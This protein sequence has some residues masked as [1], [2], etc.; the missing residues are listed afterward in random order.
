M[1]DWLLK[2]ENEVLGYLKY[3]R[4]DQPFFYFRFEP[5]PAFATVRRLFEDE[6]RLLDGGRD[7]EWMEICEQIDGLDLTLVSATD[8]TELR[9]F[10]LHIDGGSAWFRA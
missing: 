3:E 10:L 2:R 4:T 1:D 6:I 8:R 9:D 7:D 5:E